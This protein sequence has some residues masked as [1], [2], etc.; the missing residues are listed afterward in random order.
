MLSYI[1]RFFYVVIFPLC[2]ITFILSSLSVMF[3][4][5]LDLILYIFRG[6]IFLTDRFINSS[7]EYF[8]IGWF[9]DLEKYFNSELWNS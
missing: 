3:I 5:L 1:L 9:V 6:S 4:F 8:C 7:Y 2:L